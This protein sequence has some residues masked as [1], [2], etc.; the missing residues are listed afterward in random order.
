MRRPDM[1]KPET[2]DSYNITKPGDWFDA[3]TD[4]RYWEQIKPKYDALSE[5]QKA[6]L[7]TIFD[8]DDVMAS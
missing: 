8:D 3:I 5:D 6:N 4:E 2:H 1:L 7:R